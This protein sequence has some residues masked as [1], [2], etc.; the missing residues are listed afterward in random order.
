MIHRLTPRLLL[1]GLMAGP[2][3]MDACQNPIDGIQI[4][5]KDPIQ[6]G[7][8]ECRLYDP[9]GNPLPKGSRVLVA[10]TLR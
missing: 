9:A 3:L 10:S 6:T 7:V 5:L 1:Y 4:R 2:L 8:V